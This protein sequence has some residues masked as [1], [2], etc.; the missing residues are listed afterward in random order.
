VLQPQPKCRNDID[1]DAVT[2]V[3]PVDHDREVR[4]PQ[5]ITCKVT[6][7]DTIPSVTSVDNLSGVNFY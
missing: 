1:A 7:D 4:L 6:V 5:T 2:D 3:S